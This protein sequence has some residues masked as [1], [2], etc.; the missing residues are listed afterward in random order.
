M[1]SL[2]GNLN[3]SQSKKK[4][5]NC[6]FNPLPPTPILMIKS[7]RQKKRKMKKRGV[8]SWKPSG[9]SSKLM[10]RPRRQRMLKNSSANMRTKAMTMECWKIKEFRSAC[11]REKL[12][13]IMP[14]Q[15]IL[16]I[17]LASNYSLLSNEQFLLTE[18]CLKIFIL[19]NQFLGL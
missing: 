15:I 10:K 3:L 19:S 8:R 6:R 17:I 4:W 18:V 2:Q 1:P 7:S 16:K 11:N 12:F 14:S 9:N 13:L 5:R